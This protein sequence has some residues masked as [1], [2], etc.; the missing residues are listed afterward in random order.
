MGAA[1]QDRRGSNPDVH[2]PGRPRALALLGLGVWNAALK[3]I[4]AGWRVID[5]HAL[6]KNPLDAVP[7]VEQRCAPR[8]AIQIFHDRQLRKRQQ[9]PH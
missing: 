8:T 1:H 5:D 6:T 3:Y 2:A 4:M 7:E 9:V